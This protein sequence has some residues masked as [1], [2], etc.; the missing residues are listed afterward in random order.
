MSFIRNQQ[1]AERVTAFHSEDARGRSFQIE[2]LEPGPNAH[3]ARIAVI[4][5][6]V[7]NKIDQETVDA[8]LTYLQMSFGVDAMPGV[9]FFSAQNTVQT[10][11]NQAIWYFRRHAGCYQAVVTLGHL[12]S[13]SFYESQRR[14]VTRLPQFFV[15]VEDP[16]S[17]GM[18]TR[19]ADVA[20]LVTGVQRILPTGMSQH[21][22]LLRELRREPLSVVL[23]YDGL[24]IDGERM[25]PHTSLVHEFSRHGGNGDV[26]EVPFFSSTNAY[27]TL[28]SHMSDPRYNVV[29]LGLDAPVLAHGDA[30][31]EM[32]EHYGKTV[33][34][35]S[36]TMVHAGAALGCGGTGE[37]YGFYAARQLYEYL[38]RQ[39]CMPIQSVVEPSVA[40]YNPHALV[41]QHLDPTDQLWQSWHA[42]P[43]PV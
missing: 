23:P 2:R 42:E 7:D 27:E 10:L 37:R 17:L 36:A 5:S 15:G 20:P 11:Y 9:D 3:G 13:L 26:L 33:F 32:A 34:S 22:Q 29:C 28:E 31:I 39:N 35:T 8:L 38:A 41:K 12:P 25:P 18:L 14:W 6:H 43:V 1:L 4:M 21:I 19:S 16:E 24:R 40:C 30:I